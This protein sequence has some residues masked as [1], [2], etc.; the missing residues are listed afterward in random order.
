M[1]ICGVAA[2][3]DAALYEAKQGG[4]VCLASDTHHEDDRQLLVVA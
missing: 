2:L 1:P 4:R 3:S